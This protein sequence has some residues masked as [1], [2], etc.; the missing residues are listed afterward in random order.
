MGEALKSPLLPLSTER[1][2]TPRPLSLPSP[3]PQGP[4]NCQ[5]FV[6]SSFNR[7][8]T[9]TSMLTHL[10][11]SQHT[12]PWKKWDRGVGTFSSL[13][14]SYTI[15]VTDYRLNSF[16][17]PW[18][19][20]SRCFSW[21][22]HSWQLSSLQHS[23]APDTFQIKQFSHYSGVHVYVYLNPFLT[24]KSYNLTAPT[25][26][27]VLSSATCTSQDTKNYSRYFKYEGI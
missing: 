16:M 7:E 24:T 27:S 20:V 10:L 25:S 15:T 21:L 12:I 4:L 19:F 17:P 13:D 18:L 22:T 5:S 23:G 1:F 9:P 11:L 3:W 8:R 14:F 6:L 26:T 2:P